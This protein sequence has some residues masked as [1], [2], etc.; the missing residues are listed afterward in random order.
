MQRR[1]FLK[2]SVGAGALTALGLVGWGCTRDDDDTDQPIRLPRL[3]YGE[4][5]LAPYL[6]EETLRLH[7]AQHHR[8]YVR[9][10]N[11]LVRDTRLEKLPLVEI[12]RQSYRPKACQQ[13]D[14]F[15]NAAQ[16]FNHTFY[17]NSMK[18]NGGGPPDGLMAE[19]LEKSFGSYEAFR[20]A[21]MAAA[22]NR[23]GSGW[24]WLVLNQGQ[25]EVLNTINAKSP[26]VGGMQP[27]LVLDVWE[28]A[29]YLDYQN[30]RDKYIDAFLDHLVDWGFA[31]N[32][33]GET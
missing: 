32:N 18:P 13:N 33:L 12:M 6:S 4:D 27:L 14:I 2:W 22:L 25:L 19:W 20:K 23:F 28:H 16:V 21:F 15:N 30:R 5:E 1:A 11:R 24:A 26:I 31:V 17:W 29:Y 3:P 9:K 8:G 7:Y 10:A